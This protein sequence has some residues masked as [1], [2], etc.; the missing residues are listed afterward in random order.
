V[1]DAWY[2]EGWCHRAEG[3]RMFR[4]DRVVGLEVLEVDG[5]PPPEAVNREDGESAYAGSPDDLVVTVDLAAR[6]R[7]VVEYYPVE[8][9]VEQPDGRLRVR[10]RTGSSDWLPRLALRLGGDLR[11]VS[12]DP[13]GDRTRELATEALAAYAGA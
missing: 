12:P 11:V 9:V 2:L 7:W 5:T 4:L 8:Q 6:A 13:V 10:L 3:V 1:G